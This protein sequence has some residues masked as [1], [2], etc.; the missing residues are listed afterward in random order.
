M[1]QRIVL[2][3]Y[4][5]RPDQAAE[6]QRLITQVFEA[7]ARERPS[8]L[9]YGSF[10]SSDGS[11]FVHLAVTDTP[12]G[13]SPLT[14]LA[15]FKAFAGGVKGRCDEAPASTELIEVGSYRLFGE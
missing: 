5:T 12:D 13:S 6:N 2:V 7:L 10:R 9:R 11:G 14:R 15:A 4:A 3:R 8:G 1:T